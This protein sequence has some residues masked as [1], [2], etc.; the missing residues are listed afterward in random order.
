M[1]RNLAWFGG[2]RLRDK[3]RILGLRG[4]LASSTD[5]HKPYNPGFP[6]MRNIPEFP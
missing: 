6:I 5:G 3:S 1:I 4:S 2:L